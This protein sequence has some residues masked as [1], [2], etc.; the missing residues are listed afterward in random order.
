MLQR[1][2]CGRRQSVPEEC[3]GAAGRPP[4]L[5]A[6]TQSVDGAGVRHAGVPSGRRVGPQAG[7]FLGEAA[8]RLRQEP[9]GLQGAQHL[10]S[11]FHSRA[12][13][14][15]IPVLVICCGQNHLYRN[16]FVALAKLKSMAKPKTQIGRHNS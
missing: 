2:R 12:I 10:Y 16:L 5:L 14:V 11:L 7:T 3:G 8:R 6:F 1:L 15:I 4:G 13:L 9:T